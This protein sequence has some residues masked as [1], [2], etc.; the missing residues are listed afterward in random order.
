MEGAPSILPRGNPNGWPKSL[1][2]WHISYMY[3]S[4][5]KAPVSLDEAK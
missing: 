5:G 2:F 1:I 4:V 3:V